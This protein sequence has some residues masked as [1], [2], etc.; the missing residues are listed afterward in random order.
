[1]SIYNQRKE[2]I[3][4]IKRHEENTNFNT[5]IFEILEGNLAE[6][7]LASLQSQL[8]INSYASAAERLS[9]VNIFRKVI[10]KVSTLYVGDVERTTELES[11]QELINYYEKNAGINSHFIEFNKGYNSYKNSVVEIY[12]S[13]GH[14]KTRTIPANMFLPYSDDSVDPLK[15]T[16]MIKFM[17]QTINTEGETTNKYWVYTANEFMPIDSNGNVIMEDLGETEGINDFGVIPFVFVN[18]SKY[19]LVPMPDKDDYKMTVLLPV[20]LTDLNFAA[21]YMAHSIFYGIDIDSENLKI[22]PDAFWNFQSEEDG[23]APQVGTIRPDVSIDEVITLIKEQM[24]VW[25]ETKDIKAGSIGSL[26]QSNVASGVSKMIDE[27]D[28]TVN[29]KSQISTF[30]MAEKVFWQVLAT[31]HNE[32]AKAGR[33]ENRALFSEPSRLEVN[34][35]FPDQKP[36]QTK[37]EIIEEASAELDAGLTSKRRMIKKLNPEMSDD[38]V[39]ELLEEIEQENSFDIPEIEMPSETNEVNPLGEGAANVESV[40]LNGAQVTSLV[41]VVQQVAK[42]ELPRESGLEI[43]MKAFNLSKEEAESVLSSA[44]KGFKITQ[45]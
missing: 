26:N 24:G 13:D 37:L 6:H 38:E 18:K 42:G 25:L 9:P 32:A 14:I 10:N 22:S 40:I 12:E 33:L 19:L 45:E 16:A 11:D 5:S 31:I 7:V 34:V 30:Q 17:G 36:M 27:A 3:E 43:I 28:A 15:V 4:H 44:G 8:S 20:L 1:M 35:K 41:T 39:S 21:K 23:K 29:R 2:I